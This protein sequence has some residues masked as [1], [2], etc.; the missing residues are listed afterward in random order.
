MTAEE[1]RRLTAIAARRI[2]AFAR[3]ETEQMAKRITA[4]IHRQANQLGINP[5]HIMDAFEAANTGKRVASAKVT[6]KAT[7]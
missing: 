7:Q 4:E 1:T 3:Q 6:I 2:N 5:L